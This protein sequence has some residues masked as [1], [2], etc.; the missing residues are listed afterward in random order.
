ML[1]Y[2][3]LN[4]II[5][6]YTTLYYKSLGDFRF[7][8]FGPDSALLG[9]QTV[10]DSY[11]SCGQ[12]PGPGVGLRSFLQAAVFSCT[13]REGCIQHVERQQH[14]RDGGGGRASSFDCCHF[15]CRDVFCL[16]QMLETACC[17][18]TVFSRT[19]QSVLHGSTNWLLAGG[20]RMVGVELQ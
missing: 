5:L 18:Q 2:T 11:M 12:C 15:H 6:Y 7:P 13:G 20:R 4:Y 9:R 16:G 8:K 19:R 14:E 1:S 3:I 10:E 17:H